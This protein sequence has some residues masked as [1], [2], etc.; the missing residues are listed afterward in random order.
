MLSQSQKDKYC[1]ILLLGGTRKLKFIERKQNG[2]CQRLAGRGI[3]ELFN[4]YR[5]S[6]EQSEEF[7]RVHNNV[8]GLNTTELYT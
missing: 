3:G 5:V 4:G 7:W 8:N 6:V 1:V 2:G